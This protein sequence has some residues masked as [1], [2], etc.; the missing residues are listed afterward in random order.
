MSAPAA[1]IL[2]A[3]ISAVVSVSVA[4]GVELSRR[5][6][7]R[8]I[9]ELQRTSSK[10]I[11]ELRVQSS[12]EI[13]R[14]RAQ[15][16][17]DLE[18]FKDELA[19]SRESATKAEEARRLVARYRDPLLR[20]AFDLQSRLYNVLQ[21]RGFRGRRDP[22]YFRLNTLFVIAE[23][24]GWLEIIRRDMQFLDLGATDV[25]RDLNA[26][27]ALV[28]DQFAST[29]SRSDEYYLYRGQQRA[30]GELMIGPAGS[31]TS[32]PGPRF[33]CIGYASFVKKNQDPD[34]SRWFERFGKEVERLPGRQPERLVC[35]QHALIDLIDLLDPGRQWYRGSRNK[36]RTSQ[37]EGSPTAEAA[38]GRW[39]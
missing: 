2:V 34:Y 15:Q 39:A 38:K 17:L 23:F 8:Q 29:S 35:V 13:E 36:L 33:E 25:T 19:K 20:S 18:G 28:Q 6:S 24:F 10:E 1:S 4:T 7:S 5:R 14:L 30:I 22:E 31:A 21:V 3:I 26:G 16:L 32:H 12:K 11:E 27:I 9:Q 37:P